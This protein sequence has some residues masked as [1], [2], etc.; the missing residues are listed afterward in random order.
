MARKD[1]LKLSAQGK[2]LGDLLQGLNESNES[3]DLRV[4]THAGKVY[5]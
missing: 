2:G 4:T 1:T 5:K 3:K